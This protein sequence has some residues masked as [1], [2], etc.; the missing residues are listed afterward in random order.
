M[1]GGKKS[2]E[3]FDAAEGKLFARVTDGMCEDAVS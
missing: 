1:Q 3:T 2:Y